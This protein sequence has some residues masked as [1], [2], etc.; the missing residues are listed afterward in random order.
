MT[1][2]NTPTS[3]SSKR[4]FWGQHIENWKSSG[5][6]QTQYCKD[7]HL[8]VPTFQYWKSKMDRLSLSRPLIP[9]TVK[10]TISSTTSSFPS[11]VSLSFKDRFNIHL[12]VGF[13]PDTLHSILDLLESR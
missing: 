9:L 11:G 6:S 4:E 7:H 5:L 8:K 2:L 1:Q 12:E 10:S 13:N 3:R